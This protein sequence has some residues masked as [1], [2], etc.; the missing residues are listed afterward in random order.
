LV[1]ATMWR[2]M[3]DPDFGAIKLVLSQI[4]GLFNIPPETFAIR[5][6]D[7]IERPIP[8]IPLP[9][10]YF[11]L[12]ITNIWLGWPF[13]T[14]VATGAL[15]SIPHDYYEAADIDGANGPQKFRHITLPLLRPAMVPAAVYGVVTTF[16]LFNL[17]YFT[18]RGGPLHQTE[19]MVS[20][21]YRLVN[22][23]RLYGIAAA[24]CVLIFFILLT[25]TLAMNRFTRATE[26]YDV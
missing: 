16:N 5:W 17:M 23:Q 18:S 26:R 13:M 2:N 15:Q 4:G 21:A 8:W 20:M 12:L 1:I 9:L 22:E 10:S 19:I 25:L 6:F 14:I 24:F 3:F 11:G 7:Q